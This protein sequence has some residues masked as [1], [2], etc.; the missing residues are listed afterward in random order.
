MRISQQYVQDTIL[1]KMASSQGETVILPSHTAPYQF[2]PLPTVFSVGRKILDFDSGY[3]IGYLILDCN[4]NVFNRIAAETQIGAG[5][6]WAAFTQKG[7]LLFASKQKLCLIPH[8]R[9]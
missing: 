3:Y 7:E 6:F 8:G 5:G 9:D 4:L 1:G 2:S